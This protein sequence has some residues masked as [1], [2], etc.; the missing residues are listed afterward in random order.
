VAS[1]KSSTNT[2]LVV[3]F[4]RTWGRTSSSAVVC[5]LTVACGDEP[6][7]ASRADAAIA[8][9]ASVTN[10]AG[11]AGV[12]LPLALAVS[13]THACTIRKAGVYCWGDNFA[14][15]LGNGNT[16]TSAAPVQ[17]SVVVGKEVVE[18]KAA[19]GRTCI[20]TSAGKIECWGAND[21]GQIG[22]GTRTDTL[23]PVPAQGIDDAI[24]LAL[25]DVSTCVVRKAGRTVACWGGGPEDAWVPRKIEGLANVIELRAGTDGSYCARDANSAVL[26]WQS[27]NGAWEA[28]RS[29]A[30]LA[31]S[32]AVVVAGFDEVCGLVKEGNIVCN[33]AD[34]GRSVPLDDSYGV[35]T[36]TAAGSLSVCANK[37][38]GS[39]YCWNVL[40]QMLE[41]FG[42]PAIAIP[43]TQ[44][45]TELLLSGFNVCA[46]RADKS[47][48]CANANEILIASNGFDPNGFK[49]VEGLPE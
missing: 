17:A 20:R 44:P 45:L 14:G 34:S 26:C 13:P 9:D 38:D 46:L 24:A 12:Q 10:D 7:S 30:A 36:L 3:G 21:H 37:R 19:T 11:G 2:G 29:V 1:P 49:A 41:D 27:G 25:D 40:R 8:G 18:L 35:V 4:A 22:D 47:V 15:Q 39:W 42:S 6:K 28:A 5:L 43:T 31:G 33:S 23:T 16:T 32:K 48:V